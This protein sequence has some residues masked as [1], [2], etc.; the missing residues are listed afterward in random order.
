MTPTVGV[1]GKP[2]I[3]PIQFRAVLEE[4]GVRY[5]SVYEESAHRSVWVQL[6]ELLNGIEVKEYDDEPTRVKIAYQGRVLDLPIQRAQPVAMPLPAKMP[7]GVKTAA[8]SAVIQD[9][10]DPV[11][12]EAARQLDEKRI[13]ATRA[14]IQRRR[15]LRA[16][17]TAGTP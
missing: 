17:A 13:E 9:Q 12:V 11:D 16:Q 15:A 7:P 10:A 14:E 3:D 2:N 5:F 4:N 1:T 6:H 8:N